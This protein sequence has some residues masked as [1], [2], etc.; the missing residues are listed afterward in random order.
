MI[1]IIVFRILP[2]LVFFGKFAMPTVLVYWYPGR[3]AEQKQQ[4]AQRMTD[5]LVEVGNAR[6][7]SILIIFQE[8]TPDNTARG[9]QLQSL[10]LLPQESSDDPTAEK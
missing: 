8:T 5:A 9:G 3:N 2:E 7:E 1:S 4:I 6:R 10:P